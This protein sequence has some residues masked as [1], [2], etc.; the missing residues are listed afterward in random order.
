MGE[1]PA[2]EVV[3]AVENGGPWRQTKT[4]TNTAASAIPAA[5]H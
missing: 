4:L 2:F 1:L 3:N 5:A